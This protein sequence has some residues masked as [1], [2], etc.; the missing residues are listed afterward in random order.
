MWFGEEE[1]NRFV[2]LEGLWDLNRELSYHFEGSSGLCGTVFIKLLLQ[3]L[4]YRIHNDITG[5][6]HDPDRLR[7]HRV[8]APT[9]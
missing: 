4:R 8:R 5:K 2:R 7:W 1:V 9:T 3:C 6:T